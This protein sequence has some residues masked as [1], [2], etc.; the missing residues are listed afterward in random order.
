[1]KEN[2]RFIDQRSNQI[3]SVQLSLPNEGTQFSQT[4]ITQPHA[5][6]ARSLWLMQVLLITLLLQQSE[7]RRKFKMSLT[8]IYQIFKQYCL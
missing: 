2:T 7:L 3:L 4:P 6:T 8:H 5:H 1:M